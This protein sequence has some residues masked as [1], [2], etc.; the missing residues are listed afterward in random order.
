M[1]EARGGRKRGTGLA[2]ADLGRWATALKGLR[3]VRKDVPSLLVASVHHRGLCG[4]CDALFATLRRVVGDAVAGSALCVFGIASAGD[5]LD[6]ECGLP[7]T[8][9]VQGGPVRT[10]H[11]PGGTVLAATHRGPDRTL[12]ESWEALYDY[13][14]AANVDVVGA[15]REVYLERDMSGREEHV[16]E[17]QVPVGLAQDRGARDA[18]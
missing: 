4:D 15:R 8:R 7:V 1:L 5:S 3:I 12:A 11:L 9:P 16:T 2:R 18:R 17:L 6:V 13:I 10:R 14:E